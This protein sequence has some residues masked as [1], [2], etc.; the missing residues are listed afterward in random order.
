MT[1]NK[2]QP[3]QRA[4]LQD[5]PQ[6]LVRIQ[7]VRLGLMPGTEITCVF[8]VN[9]GPVIISKNL[10]QIAIGQELA[11]QITVNTQAEEGKAVGKTAERWN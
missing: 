9:R 10:Q 7:A 1:L 3:G 4:T 2:L 6:G 8:R 11:R 5:L